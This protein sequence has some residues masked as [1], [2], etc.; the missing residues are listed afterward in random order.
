M[1]RN[2]SSV[3]GLLGYDEARRGGPTPIWESRLYRERRAR[4]TAVA[5]RRRRL[6][7]I[8]DA[9]LLREQRALVDHLLDLCERAELSLRRRGGN[10]AADL[11]ALENLT[12]TVSMIDSEMS[13]EIKRDRLEEL[14]GYIEAMVMV[15]EVARIA[16]MLE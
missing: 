7:R 3:K 1:A 14:R 10:I 2:R 4:E 5:L 15:V 9:E 12:F 6:G 13:A 8:H 11:E 16:S